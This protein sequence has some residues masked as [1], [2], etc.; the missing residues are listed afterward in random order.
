[1]KNKGKLYSKEFRI[2]SLYKI[3]SK[4]G[5]MITFKMNKTQRKLFD[6]QKDNPRII[7]LKARQL[8]MSTYKLVEWLDRALF[9]KNQ[10]VIITAHLQSKLTE[11][12]EK[13]KLAYENL[14]SEIELSDWSIWTKPKADYNNRNELYFKEINSKIR[15]SLDSRSWTPTSLH[16]TELAFMQ[17]AKAMWTW[18][19]PSI[20][21]EA[22]VTVET[23]ANWLNFFSELWD[24]YYWKKW[25]AFETLFFPWY[26][27]DWYVLEN[28]NWTIPSELDHLYKLEL[29][30]EQINWYANQYELLWKEVF[31]EFPSTPEEAFLTTWNPVFNTNILKN[32]PILEFETDLKYSDLRIYWKPCNECIYWVDTSLWWDDWDLS[33]ITVRTRD[34]KLLAT[35]MWHIPPDKLWEM[36]EYIYNLWY[37]TDW[38]TIWVESNNTWISTLDYLKHTSLNSYL[39]SQVEVDTRTQRRTKKLW[40]NTNIKTRPLIIN[41]IEEMIRKGLLIELDERAKIDFFHFIYNEKNKPEAIIWKHDD[42]VM[43]EAICLFMVNQPKQII[44]W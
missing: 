7:I 11:L 22:P 15:V 25:G 9:W 23:T 12:F 19:M 37:K 21:K 3:V 16:I 38:A 24:K 29:S 8:W 5:E 41:N 44:F 1:M 13:V 32:L 6:V 2:N 34:L 14:P 35:Y 10:T 18:S 36:I 26:D 42:G 33:V 28:Y 20:P 17:T 27:D 43:A 39:Y 4:E 40:F 30:Q 31:Q